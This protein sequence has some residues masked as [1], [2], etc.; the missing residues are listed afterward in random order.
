M[1]IVEPIVQSLIRDGGPI[2][3]ILAFFAVLLI[4]FAWM[5]RWVIREH[6]AERAEWNRL[7]HGEREDWRA[8]MRAYHEGRQ[9]T[10]NNTVDALTE[11]RV[12]IAALG[13]SRSRR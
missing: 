9:I 4:G 3:I 12:A 5:V 13:T 1:D 2:G 6:R 10:Q 11:L 7:H 8:D